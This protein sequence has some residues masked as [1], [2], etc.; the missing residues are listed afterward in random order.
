MIALQGNLM[1]SKNEPNLLKISHFI[2]EWK[3]SKATRDDTI[4]NIRREVMRPLFENL[5]QGISVL[6]DVYQHPS[7]MPEDLEKAIYALIPSIIARDEI[8]NLDKFDREF[9]VILEKIDGFLNKIWEA[10]DTAADTGK[11]AL[12]NQFK[13]Y[14]RSIT[15]DPSPTDQ[16]IFEVISTIQ[17]SNEPGVRLKQV[18]EEYKSKTQTEWTRV[19]PVILARMIAN[20]GLERSWELSK[21]PFEEV[22]TQPSGWDLTCALVTRTSL[23]IEVLTQKGKTVR[24]AVT[25]KGGFTLRMWNVM[26]TFKLRFPGIL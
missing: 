10:P 16:K 14:I 15:Q 26:F 18:Y 3:D 25:E 21:S 17:N 11:V 23:E 24:D 12:L 8:Q 9:L 2:N 13:D 4:I 19:N 6:K 20:L 5:D 1:N 22:T 7:F